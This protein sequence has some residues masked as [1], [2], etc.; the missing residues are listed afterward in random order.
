MARNIW[1]MYHKL[2]NSYLQLYEQ[3]VIINS[4]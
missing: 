4:V 2:T 3:L 1:E